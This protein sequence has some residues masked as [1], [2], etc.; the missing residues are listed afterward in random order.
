[1]GTLFRI[2]LYAGDESA[3]R[4]AADFAFDRVDLLEDVMSDYQ[5]DSELNLLR[6][7]E[8]GVPVKVSNDLFA[9]LQK[10]QELSRLTGGAFDVTLGPYTR[11]W[12]FSRKRK[13]LPSPAELHA[14]RAVSGYR[15]LTLDPEHH[16]VTQRVP[17]MRLD[18]GGIAKGYAA[19]EAL[20]SLKSLGFDRALVAASG[21]IAIGNP[22]P[23]AR[24]WSIAIANPGPATNS[25]AKSLLLHNAGVSTSGDTEQFV[26]IEGVRY[27]H[28]LDPQTGLGLTNSIQAT[29]IAPKAFL[30]DPLATAVCIM[31][32][33]KGFKVLQRFHGTRAVVIEGSGEHKKV[34]TF[35]RFE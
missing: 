6:E 32:P 2:V 34:S 23:G 24:G 30:S 8:P 27:A 11:L 31:G 20:A 21:D 14:A 7:Q 4:A 15:N 35:G 26:E 16:T 10:G 5:A 3:A 19:D 9:V 17:G 28:I 29:V 18:V 13:T 22:P 12:R 1:M 25:A 33:Q